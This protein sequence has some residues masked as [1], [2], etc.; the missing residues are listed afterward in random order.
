MLDL[1]KSNQEDIFRLSYHV[2]NRGAW[3]QLSTPNRSKPDSPVQ[4]HCNPN[5]IQELSCTHQCLTRS[6]WSLPYFLSRFLSPQYILYHHSLQL[7]NSFFLLIYIYFQYNKNVFFI[8]LVYISILPISL[9]ISLLV[10]PNMKCPISPTRQDKV[11]K[12]RM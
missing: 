8:L 5:C 1:L 2:E 4:D 10:A 7:K 9:A 6:S 3:D 11:N 12:E